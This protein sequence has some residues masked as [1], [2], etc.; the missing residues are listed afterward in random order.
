MK[1]INKKERVLILSIILLIISVAFI[2]VNGNIYTIRYKYLGEV[3]DIND[4]SIKIADE[5]IIKCIDK[6][7]KNGLLEIKIE[8]KS[9]G[10]TFVDVENNKN[11]FSN[12]SSIYVHKFGTITFN[13]FMGDCSGSIIIPIS[14]IILLSYVLYLIIL[15]YK[16]NIKLNMYQ[17]KNI[18]YLGIIVFV[19]FS[20]MCQLF[21]VFGYKGLIHTINGILSMFS[22]AIIL[23]P[24]AFVVSILVI[25]SNISLIRKEGF[26]LKNTLG[27]VLG[28]CLCLSTMLPDIIYNSLYSATW[29]DIHNQNGIGL[30]IYNLV[31]TI[32]YTAIT[33]IECILIGTIIMGVKAAKHIPEFDK[34]CIIILGCKI[35]KMEH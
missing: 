35:K 29:I 11:G 26:N 7:I 18:A 19:S 8:S 14:I 5:N 25:L 3:E 10:K 24:I 32:I 33:Y 30:Y 20:I 27:I 34:D 23:L 6:N 16:E 22:F 1:K 2:I 15:S 17:Y 28:V 12:L 21:A 31:E 9:E 13:E 4:V